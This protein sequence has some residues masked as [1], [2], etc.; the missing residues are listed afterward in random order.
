MLYIASLRKGKGAVINNLYPFQCPTKGI[1]E[2]V[3][4][5]YSFP[6]FTFACLALERSVVG[7]CC[8]VGVVCS[9]VRAYKTWFYREVK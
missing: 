3:Y 2:G 9:E 6:D 8:G 4:R 5:M 7:K 1:C